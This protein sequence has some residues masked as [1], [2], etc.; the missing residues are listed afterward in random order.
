MARPSRAHPS[1]RTHLRCLANPNPS[2]TPPSHPIPPA[3]AH[4]PRRACLTLGRWARHGN[5]QVV[6]TQEEFAAGEAADA[7]HQTVHAVMPREGDVLTLSLTICISLCAFAM[8]NLVAPLMQG[9]R[10]GPF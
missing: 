9:T 6:G 8:L 4:P 7:Y 10:L 5:T 3:I 1:R 2:R